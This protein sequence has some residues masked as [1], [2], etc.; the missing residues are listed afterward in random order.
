MHVR[1]DPVRSQ[2]SLPPRDCGT[3]L[4][5]SPEPVGR[6]PS[7]G[8]SQKTV[9]GAF[10]ISR[11]ARYCPTPESWLLLRSLTKAPVTHSKLWMPTCASDASPGDLYAPLASRTPL[12]LWTDSERP[13]TPLTGCE[14][15]PTPLRG[16]A[17]TP[18]LVRRETASLMRASASLREPAPGLPQSSPLRLVVETRM[19]RAAESPTLDCQTVR[20]S[21]GLIRGRLT[22]PRPPQ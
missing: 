6:D 5:R 1:R 16:S 10:E 12:A 20:P 11:K 9:T 2:T 8:P 19:T 17:R 18:T 14:R 21:Y 3:R 13:P 15:R 7:C 22:A 4:A